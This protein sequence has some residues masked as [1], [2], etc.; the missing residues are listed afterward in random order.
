[1]AKIRNTGISFSPFNR[2]NVAKQMQEIQIRF[3][4]LIRR[5]YDMYILE[6]VCFLIHFCH[7]LNK[8]VFPVG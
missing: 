1:M 6:S 3:F 8:L 4:S 5:R 2:H 7:K